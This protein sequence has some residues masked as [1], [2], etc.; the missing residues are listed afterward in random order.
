MYQIVDFFNWISVLNITGNG[1]FAT[2]QMIDYNIFKNVQIVNSSK[3]T[4]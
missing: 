3:Y 4:D 2:E 1:L